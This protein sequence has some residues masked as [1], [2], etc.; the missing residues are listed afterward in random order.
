MIGC[1]VGFCVQWVLFLVVVLMVLVVELVFGFFGL[2]VSVW[3]YFV[4][5][6]EC[7]LALFCVWLSMYELCFG[8][9]GRDA[10]WG[11]S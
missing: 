10:V 5:T 7:V 4:K 9:C 6:C 11:L 1:G 2:W 8:H 3:E